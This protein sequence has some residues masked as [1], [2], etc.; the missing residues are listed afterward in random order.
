MAQGLEI[1][2]VTADVDES[3]LP[4]L[5]PGPIAAELAERKA[6]AVSG[7]TLEDARWVLGGDTLV[8]VDDPAGG[9]PTYLGKPGTPEEARAMLASLS[10]TTHRVVTGVAALRLEDG[11]V[12]SAA[13]TTFVTMRPIREA[14][15]DA[16][17]ATGEWEGKAGGYAIQESADQFVEQLAGGGFDNVVGL[18]VELALRLLRSLGWVDPRS[19]QR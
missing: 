15:L 14:E 2:V 12:I 6:C 10:G 4:E 8:V 13:E 18:P 9:L 5:D 19:Q 16:Y 1:S 17:V 7:L 11:K 3:F